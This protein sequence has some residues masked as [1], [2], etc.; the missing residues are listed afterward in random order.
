MT[1]TGPSA[2]LNRLLGRPVEVHFTLPTSAQQRSAWREALAAV[3]CG[4]SEALAEQLSQRYSLSVGAIR[5]VVDEAHA[6]CFSALDGARSSGLSVEGIAAAVRARNI[7]ALGQ[8]AQPFSTTLDWDDV[9]LPEEVLANLQEIADHARLRDKVFDDWGFRRKV[10]YGRGLSCLF[11]GP[12]GTGKT[13][14]AAVLAKSLG[15]DL[16]RI[17]MARISSKW[18]GETEKNLARIFD[19]AERAQVILLF[20]EADSLFATRTEGTSSADRFANMEVNYLLQRMEAYDGMTILTTNFETSID[21]AFKR[22]L[23]FT[24]TFPMPG[25]DQRRLLWGSMLPSQAPVAEGLD[26]SE[27]AEEFELSDGV[28]K[29]AVVR[30]AFYAA[31]E[32][33]PIT[34]D[35]LW[36]AAVAETREMGML[37]RDER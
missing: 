25:V 33:R 23:R 24:V 30:A 18:V 8:V 9:V 37:V 7:H 20:D 14:L 27:L 32:D 22:R 35:D 13:M 28:I 2:S 10:S 29:K 5:G 34:L 12:P 1:T 17:D 16:Y 6:A 4:E 36:D 15:R 3:E 26:M 31:G 21:E 19:E 11:V